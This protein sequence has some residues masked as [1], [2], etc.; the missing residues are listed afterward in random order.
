M[1]LFRYVIVFIFAFSSYNQSIASDSLWTRGFI[2]P[3]NLG[4][5]LTLYD[6]TFVNKSL[7]FICGDKGVIF[8]TTNAGNTWEQKSS[9]TNEYLHSIIFHDST[10]GS[11]SK[12]GYAIGGK[13][14]ICK[15]T[16]Q[17]ESWFVE[18][19]LITKDLYKISMFN[20]YF[21]W[22]I[23]ARGTVYKT[24][25]Q[26]NTWDS[27]YK[28]S[29]E[30]SDMCFV[31]NYGWAVGG[32]TSGII[33]HTSNGG[34]K[35]EIQD[36][37]SYKWLLS[38]FFLDKENG[39]ITGFNGT[40]IHT[41]DGG[42]NWIKQESGTIEHILTIR[43]TDLNNGWATSKYGVILHTI[44]GGKK[45]SKQVNEDVTIFTKLYF[46]DSDNGWAVGYKG[47]L[48]KYKSLGTS[49][50]DNQTIINNISY[51]PN[52]SKDYLIIKLDSVPLA[53]EVIE[54]YDLMGQNLLTQK[55]ENKETCIKLQN[56]ITGIYYCKLK[57]NGTV[58]KFEVVR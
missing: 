6:I 3:S 8:K 27:I 36:T 46:F 9:S 51:Y 23:G 22:I 5:Y 39:W 32:D 20:D 12:V 15:S 38:V 58:F 17:G 25:N 35:W 28:A 49:V 7:G 54:V 10:S 40:I 1:K 14:T 42:K 37:M 2:F 11:N 16:D 41:S 24:S 33:L 31:S 45:W 44:D 52:P 47:Y 50:E 18:N 4:P 53:N 56:L 34:V 48:L 55:I 13:G 57:Q 30:L 26:G 21:G 19:K 29:K 43:F